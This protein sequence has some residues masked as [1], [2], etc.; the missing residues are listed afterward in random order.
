MN[1]IAG[2]FEGG[3]VAAIYRPHRHKRSLQTVR[4]DAP[5]NNVSEVSP[6]FSSFATAVRQELTPATPL[7]QVLAERAIV[8]SWRLH[9]L[10]AA[11]T[12]ALEK[13]GTRRGA[14]SATMRARLIRAERALERALRLFYETRDRRAPRWG[15]VEPAAAPVRTKETLE[16]ELSA[17]SNEWPVVPDD[18][19]EGPESEEDAAGMRWQ[20]RL[21]FDFNVS[22]IS[23]VV[24]GTWVTAGHVVSLIVDGWTWSDIL[25]THPELTE[26]DVRT[27]LAYTVAQDNGSDF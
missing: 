2:N 22:E 27:C 13:A 25:R 20:D 14:R 23:P 1:R 7:E 17:V 21:V 6:D 12:A 10:T 9:T 19:R 4:H 3:E 16:P 26:D 15:K 11:E 24:K 5:E 8:A 18:E